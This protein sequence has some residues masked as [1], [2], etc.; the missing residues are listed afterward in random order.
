[1][2][3]PGVHC[4]SFNCITEAGRNVYVGLRDGRV[5]CIYTTVGTAVCLSHLGE[6]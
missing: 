1:M 5:A 4:H 6:F 2:V 3:F